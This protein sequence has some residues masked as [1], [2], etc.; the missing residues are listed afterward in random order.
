M[1]T[2]IIFIFVFFNFS[3]LSQTQLFNDQVRVSKERGRIYL[4]GQ[5]CKVLDKEGEALSKWTTSIKEQA[6]NKACS[7][8]RG[9]CKKEVT[10]ALPEFV[11]AYQFKHVPTDGPNCWNATLVAAKIVPQVRYTS[12]LEMNFWMYSPLCTERRPGEPPQPGDII[13]IR[14]STYKEVHGFVY[15]SENLSFSKNG[16]DREVPYSL[17]DPNVVF[18]VYRVPENC[19]RVHG[20]APSCSAY[21][22]YY[23]CMSMDDYLKVNPI[24]DAVAKKA[25]E[26]LSDAECQI[27][28]AVLSGTIGAQMKH[29]INVNL[30][31]INTLAYE[32]LV[33]KKFNHED[34]VVWQALVHKSKSLQEQ[35]SLL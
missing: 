22:N 1:K 18:D 31:V 13:A 4:I 3:A 10:T 5:D 35:L 7:C 17:Q 20:T 21:A 27:S 19:R 24:K 9:V 8:S 6:Q 15:I 26:Q 16:Y 29:F 14:D 25:Y 11:E 32:T 2:F 28:E 34:K 23:S 33:S 12:D 30:H